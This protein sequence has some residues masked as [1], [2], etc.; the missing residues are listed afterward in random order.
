LTTLVF[1]SPLGRLHPNRLE[2]RGER[3]ILPLWLIASGV[4]LL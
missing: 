3:H 1:I 4:A 2:A